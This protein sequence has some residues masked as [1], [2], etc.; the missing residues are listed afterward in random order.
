MRIDFEQIKISATKRWT[1]NGKRRQKT[2]HFMQTI[3]PFNKNP[4][5]SVKG[6]DQIY[7]EI[8]A[9]RD[10]WLAGGK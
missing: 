6:R 3:N 9:E 7:K 1:E 8:L 10:R 4:D 2:K 5:G